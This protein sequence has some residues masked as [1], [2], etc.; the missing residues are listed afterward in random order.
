MVFTMVS[1][2]LVQVK[3]PEKLLKKVEKLCKDGYYRSKEDVILDAL[4]RL[5]KR[6]EHMDEPSRLTE[7][8]ILGKV[9]KK[10]V[11]ITDVTI[12][13]NEELITKNIAEYFGTNDV[14]EIL[15]H[16]RR[17]LRLSYS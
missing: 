1:S 13:F 12:D 5:L 8:S 10:D 3:I 14:S 15:N 7:L 9:S 16:I 2:V 6:Y 4:R 11:D 17:R